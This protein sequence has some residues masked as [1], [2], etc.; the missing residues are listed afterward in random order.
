MPLI[1]VEH[2]T[3]EYQLGTLTGFKGNPAR[4]GAGTD[5]EVGKD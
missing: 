4:D 3:K 5:L 1:E 2:V